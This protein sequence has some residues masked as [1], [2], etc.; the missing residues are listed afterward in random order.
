MH[1]LPS[2]NSSDDTSSPTALIGLNTR[3]VLMNRYPPGNSE[4]TRQLLL[5]MRVCEERNT[6]LN[7]ENHA[8]KDDKHKL[9]KKLTD[10]DD[11]LLELQKEHAVQIE[12]LKKELRETIRE[13][14]RSKFDTLIKVLLPDTEQK[15]PKVYE[16]P[17][18]LPPEPEHLPKIDEATETDDV[19]S[20]AAKDFDAQEHP[21][22]LADPLEVAECVQLREEKLKLENALFTL[23]TK[24][25]LMQFKI[26][27]YMLLETK[28]KTLEN[29]LLSLN[30]INTELINENECLKQQIAEAKRP[31]K[32][33][34]TVEDSSE[35]SANKV[36]LEGSQSEKASELMA[37]SR[38]VKELEAR[39][40]SESSRYELLEK[41]FNELRNK[42]DLLMQQSG[43]LSQQNGESTTGVLMKKIDELKARLA[44]YVGLCI[45]NE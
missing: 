45:R 1:M 11:K 27:K 4:S 19:T 3:N 30:D 17:Y 28:K 9:E 14:E 43:H 29:R 25:K 21:R 10:L 37:S 16:S 33:D 7:F 36:C 41:Q 23:E 12:A 31:A 42:H 34:Q 38:R 24:Q 18:K 40:S 20:E 6:R 44:K 35:A 39:L 5:R 13:Q 15:K 26:D 8:L 32:P 22:R 2:L